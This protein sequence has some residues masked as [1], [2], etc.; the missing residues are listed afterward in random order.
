M[1][2]QNDHANQYNF[3]YYHSFILSQ[4][5]EQNQTL[6]PEDL[7]LGEYTLCSK[8]KTDAENIYLSFVSFLENTIPF[9]RVIEEEVEIYEETTDPNDPNFFDNL[10]NFMQT[11]SEEFTLQ[12]GVGL[13]ISPTFAHSI[14]KAYINSSTLNSDKKMQEL[15]QTVNPED[16]LNNVTLPEKFNVFLSDIMMGAVIERLTN[17]FKGSEFIIAGNLVIMEFNLLQ[18]RLK[19][20]LTSFNSLIQY[21]LESCSSNYDF[22]IDLND[23]MTEL[24]EQYR[25]SSE[26][27]LDYNSLIAQ[28]PAETATER[29]DLVKTIFTIVIGNSW[30]EIISSTY[31]TNSYLTTVY[32]NRRTAL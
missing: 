24:L 28:I 26:G 8:A 9:K 12:L 11:K 6:L 18:Y 14:K 1:T 22:A 10:L 32:E 3:P 17:N 31:I 5:D 23:K 16:L 30:N 13:T 19:D 2:T 20:K 7:S 15:L 25:I 21:L 29:I 4:Q 27:T